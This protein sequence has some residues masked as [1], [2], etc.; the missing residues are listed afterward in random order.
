MFKID[1]AH[2]EHV[3]G[4]KGKLIFAVSVVGAKASH[5]KAMYSCSLGVLK[6]SGR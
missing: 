1:E 6:E 5:R 2:R 4:E 3:V